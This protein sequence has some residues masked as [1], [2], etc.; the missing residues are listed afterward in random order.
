MDLSDRSAST[1]SSESQIEHVMIECTF[2]A[3]HSRS[4]VP[5]FISLQTRTNNL[6]LIHCFQ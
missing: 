3:H 1:S 6:L 2:P 5:P 4:S